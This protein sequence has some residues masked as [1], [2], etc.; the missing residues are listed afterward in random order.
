MPEKTSKVQVRVPQKMEGDVLLALNLA[1]GVITEV[2][3]EAELSTGIDATIPTKNVLKF[4]TWLRQFSNEQGHISE[5]PNET[6]N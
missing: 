2:R 3:K 1:D 6:G 4:T 5:Y